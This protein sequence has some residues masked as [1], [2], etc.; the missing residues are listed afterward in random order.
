ME[1]FSNPWIVGIG[2]S[3]ISGILVGIITR[4]IFSGGVKK[5]YLHKIQAANNE[6]LDVIRHSIAEKV[7]PLFE[8]IDSIRASISKKYGVS[9]SDLYNAITLCNDIVKEIME[10]PFLSSKEKVDF[11]DLVVGV[12]KQHQ[13]IEEDQVDKSESINTGKSE[14][15]EFLSLT[16][17]V[18]T[19]GMV[20]VTTTLISLMQ[21]KFG[22]EGKPVFETL[23]PVL[24]VATLV[25][26]LFSVVIVAMRRFK[27]KTNKAVLSDTTKKTNHDLTKQ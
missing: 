1:L 2:G 27:K 11:C 10:S 21:N 19:A 16:L 6:I 25:P 4:Y 8:V 9:K 14:S 13:G 15:S 22:I 17:G 24:I 5:E 26:L 12:K 7:F 23:L 3:M 20:I 18:T